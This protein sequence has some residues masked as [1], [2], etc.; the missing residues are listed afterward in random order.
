M[1]SSLFRNRV[2]VS[3]KHTFKLLLECINNNTNKA[4]YLVVSLK[5]FCVDVDLLLDF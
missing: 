1:L 3:T 4:I 2:K 5:L